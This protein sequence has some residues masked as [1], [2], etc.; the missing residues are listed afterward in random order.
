MN[1]TKICKNYKALLK[2]DKSFNMKTSKKSVFCEYCDKTHTL[3]K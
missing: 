3:E 1:E 2:I